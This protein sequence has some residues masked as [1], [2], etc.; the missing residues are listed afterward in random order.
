MRLRWPYVRRVV[1]S[2][3]I[4]QGHEDAG[5][6]AQLLVALEAAY[7]A[8]FAPM[9]EESLA[10]GLSNTIAGR[11][12]NYFDL[13][14]GGY[15]IDG[16]CSSSLLAVAHACRALACGDLD[17]AL[18]GGVDLSLDPFEL[19]GFARIGAL[20]HGSMKIYDRD[21]AGFL[22]GEG[23]G[24]AVL[25]RYE[26][27]IAQGARC[28]AL[29]RGWGISSDGGGGLT[30]PE[31]N[32]QALAIERA[33]QQT[34]YGPD[35]VTYFEGHGT[36]TPVGDGVELNGIA[37]ARRQGR[38]EHTSLGVA[39]A[40]GSIKANIGHT[41]AA[42]GIAGFIK[43]TLA[44][45]N[46][47]LPPST[48]STTRHRVLEQQS[49][50]LRT[51]DRGEIWPSNQPLRAGVSSF[52][53]GGINVHVAIEAASCERRQSLSETEHCLLRS[54][55]DV[56][57][58]LFDAD[59][60]TAL[61]ELLAQ[62]ETR[63]TQLSEAELTDLSCH[64]ASALSG[65]PYRAAVVAKDP[66]ELVSKLQ[67]IR[68]VIN[69]GQ[70]TRYDAQRSVFF[71]VAQEAPRIGFLFPG[72]ASPVRTRP[73]P[74]GHRF[75]EVAAIYAGANL[76]ELPGATDFDPRAPS[77]DLA[78]PC[79]V[80]AQLAGLAL[81][82]ALGITADVSMGHS[83]GELTALHW[84]GALSAQTLLGLAKARGA[85]MAIPASA[86]GVMAS[87][88]A[89]VEAVERLSHELARNG[90]ACVEIAA[91][92]SP[93]QTVV[94]GENNAVNALLDAANKRGWNTVRLPVSQAF[95][96]RLMQPALPVLSAHL[97]GL[98]L[99]PLQGCVISS[100]HA[101]ELEPDENLSEL[102]LEQLVQPVLCSQALEVISARTD[103][104]IEVG[105]GAVLS[106][107][108][109]AR[110]DAP[111]TIGLDVGATSLNGVLSAAGAAFV[112]GCDLS[113]TTLFVERFSRPFDL[114]AVPRF[115]ANP[116]ESL[117]R[118]VTS[119]V[120]ASSPATESSVAEPC[121]SAP[122][123]LVSSATMDDCDADDS[124]YGILVR[125]LAARAELPLSSIESDSRLLN[126]L[127][128]NSIAVA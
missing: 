15:T 9:T 104:C 122:A 96:S 55:Q 1:D 67:V 79:I 98:R 82:Q 7:K 43:A 21:S 23:C 74:L 51:L 99:R 5:Q 100:V 87:V 32:G 38:G 11:I 18:A 49:A 70:T 40:I 27:A 37:K 17:V 10:G 88:T 36:G 105:P 127:H 45:H 44:A 75:D 58:F 69:Q 42:A 50:E 53:F 78:Q 107:L 2:T 76:G 113:L 16:A 121:F 25:M 66:M 22:P 33:Y 34:S 8:P 62:V 71:G 28:Y 94:S 84:A 92:N 86:H 57:L 97:D 93:Q 101:R 124:P 13:G 29:V 24:F 39:A 125:C 47:V 126:D 46:Q 102:L 120:F 80:T 4:A 61:D 109:A 54:A 81:M 6:R 35:E 72:Q 77:T 60:P 31:V 59:T 30:R 128:L 90:A 118:S 108:M 3:L 41:K 89:P 52:G 111:A 85:A 95:H 20:S 12:C 103:L 19:V 65:R 68:G 112:A 91:I 106:T 123:E 114:Q 117:P 48:G 115:L 64:L 14:G 26:D 73:G 83:L 63:A 119:T 110:M 56:E 116:C